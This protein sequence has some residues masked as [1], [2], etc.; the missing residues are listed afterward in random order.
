MK[1]FVGYHGTNKKLA[2]EI[3]KCFFIDSD[4]DAWL[5]AGVYFYED[6]DG[7][8][9]GK[10]LAINWAVVVKKYNE[11][12]IYQADIIS[13]KVFDMI[14][15][16]N[17]QNKF[18]ELKDELL[19]KHIQSGKSAEEF[20]DCDVYRHI[21]RFFEVIR[22]MVD[23]KKYEK[24]FPQTYTNIL[25]QIQLCVCNNSSKVIQNIKRLN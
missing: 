1:K 20:S 23:G 18:M 15:N 7:L 14:T 13:D 16:K 3:D 9:D 8:F 10:Q 12:V 4:P 19:K 17:L 25:P 24:N 21:T 22:V 5:G 11:Y 6:I 2:I